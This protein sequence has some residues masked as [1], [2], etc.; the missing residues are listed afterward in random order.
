MCEQRLHF[1]RTSCWKLLGVNNLRLQYFCLPN[2]DGMFGFFKGGG[3]IKVKRQIETSS[4]P[5]NLCLLSNNKTMQCQYKHTWEVPDL[6]AANLFGYE[7]IGSSLMDSDICKH[8]N[9][10]KRFSSIFGCSLL[11]SWGTLIGALSSDLFQLF[12]QYSTL[13]IQ[14]LNK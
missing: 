11:T 1:I 7:W 8:G 14:C 5:A 13:F 2:I 9:L 12:V 10:D 6:R 3:F 4:R